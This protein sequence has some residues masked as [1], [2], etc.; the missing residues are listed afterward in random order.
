M[1]TKNVMA[2]GAKPAQE[3]AADGPPVEVV[4]SLG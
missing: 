4:F 2:A 1:G 3:D